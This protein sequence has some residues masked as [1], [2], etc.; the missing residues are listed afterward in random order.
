[1][2]ATD[3]CLAVPL[4][5]RLALLT[6]QPALGRLPRAALESLAALLGE[7]QVPAGAV[8]VTEGDVADHCFVIVEGQAEVSSKGPTGFVPLATLGPGELFGEIGLLRTD[9]VRQAT[10][11]AS[12]SLLALSLDRSA[13]ERLLTLY[14]SV[15]VNFEAAADAML[16]AKFLKQAS[17]FASLDGVTLRRLADRL[18]T[19]TV[20]TGETILRQGEPGDACYLVR[21]GRV[22]VAC[23]EQAGGGERRVA[24][25]GPGA[26]FGEGA[27]LTDA[28]RNA[29]VR[30]VEPTEL[31][32]L[33]REA[34][35]EVMGANRNLGIQMVQLVHLRDRPARA[36]GVTAYER[37]NPDSEVITILKHRTRGAYYR[38]SPEGRF[39]WDRLDGAHTL[40]DL[41]LDYLDTFKA[42][43]PQSIAE[44]VA[45][46]AGAGFL[47]GRKVRADVLDK[48]LHLVWWQHTALFVRR[49]LVWQVALSGVDRALSLAF[50]W[51]IHLLYTLGGQ[52][53][54]GVLALVGLGAFLTGAGRVQP[55][56]AATEIGPALLAWLAVGYVLSIVVHEAGHA[57]TTKACGREV[58]RIGIGWY[59]FSPIAFVDTSDM[60]LADRWPR[61]A[62]SL[63]GPYASVLVGSGSALATVGVADPLAAAAL[64]L[65]ALAAYA[66]ALF[67][68][69]P[70][71]EFDGYYIVM[72]YL[73]RPNLRRDTLTWL[74][75]QLPAALGDPRQLHGRRLEL[76]YA[77]ASLGY[78]VLQAVLIVILYRLFAH[79]W[80][81]GVVPGM[82]A[83]SLAWMLA[84]LVTLLALLG[85][86]GDFRAPRPVG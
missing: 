5:R 42:F 74:G 22:A 11:T 51:G 36:P 63:A 47:E 19:L 38:L 41:T 39:V 75:H 53:V 65:I 72:D 3:R 15:R 48:T 32:V 66:T 34:L 76:A 8:V 67:N 55:I 46:L 9:A 18:T 60:W 7:E 49:A 28:P 21:T 80:L 68:L 27:L 84:G 78:I 25:L 16:E 30:A 54:L 14:P 50:R 70:L 43:A 2:T 79:D 77:L 82:V 57:F 58:P 20:E 56:L 86:A 1:M 4:A 33:P 35:H 31:L 83:D 13:F 61:I 52:V 81:I 45:G 62:V 23:T 40:R 24:S 59:W 29:T 12:R 69:N 85:V 10:V 17:P 44:T 6:A 64:W 26:L 37:A 71:L 73:E